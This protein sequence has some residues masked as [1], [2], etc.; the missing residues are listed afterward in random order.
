MQLVVEMSKKSS[1][2]DWKAIAP[3]LQWKVECQHTFHSSHALRE[4]A[5]SYLR[6]RAYLYEPLYL[7]MGMP[8]TFIV[9][10]YK[11]DKDGNPEKERLTPSEIAYIAG[12][13]KRNAKT[14]T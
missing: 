3:C 14:D 4:A 5:L 1:K 8:E 10:N 7:A 9:N 11:T 2:I 12:G 6:L 13:L